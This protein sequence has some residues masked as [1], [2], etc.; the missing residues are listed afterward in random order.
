MIIESNLGNIDGDI[1]MEMRD[2]RE[3]LSKINKSKRK[4]LMAF[5]K[6]HDGERTAI[7]PAGSTEDLPKNP[8]ADKGTVGIILV[9]RNPYNEAYADYWTLVDTIDNDC[10]ENLLHFYKRQDAVADILFA[11][12]AHQ[13]DAKPANVYDPAKQY[14]LNREKTGRPCRILS[15]VEKE[16]ID[17]MRADGKSIAE[18]ARTLKASNRFIINYLKSKR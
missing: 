13:T 12:P 9:C 16:Q 11:R 5:M 8:R 1:E 7:I 2:E 3:I 6:A 17:G 15:D 18:I 10:R 4:K 14:V